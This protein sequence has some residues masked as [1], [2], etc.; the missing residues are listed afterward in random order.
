VNLTLASWEIFFATQWSAAISRYRAS[1]DLDDVETIKNYNSLDSIQ[2]DVL[3]GVPQ[4]ISLVQP[5]LEH[6]SVF[7]EFFRTKLVANLDK[8]F[9]WGA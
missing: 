7:T 8:T 1:L 6:L 5:A 4:S 3:D 2:S 9:F